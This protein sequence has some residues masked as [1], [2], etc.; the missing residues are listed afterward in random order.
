M[1]GKKNYPL[2]KE[3]SDLDIELDDGI[4]TVN[5]LKLEQ[6]IKKIRLYI[7]NPILSFIYQA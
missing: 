4:K 2:K 7:K 6:T 5:T 1:H 3:T